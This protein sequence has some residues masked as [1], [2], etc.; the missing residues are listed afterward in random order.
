MKNGSLAM[1][2]YSIVVL[3]APSV[4]DSRFRAGCKRLDEEVVIKL[5]KKG[6]NG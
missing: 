1:T 5:I 2:I 3:Q 6:K 4:A